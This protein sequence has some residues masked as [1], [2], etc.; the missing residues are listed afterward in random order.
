M[1]TGVYIYAQYSHKVNELTS[2]MGKKHC[3]NLF[4]LCIFSENY[5]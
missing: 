1:Y 3:Y 2:E 4:I 5:W